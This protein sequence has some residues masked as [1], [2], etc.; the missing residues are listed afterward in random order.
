M[1]RLLFLTLMT[2][3]NLILQSISKEFLPLLNRR[4][5]QQNLPLIVNI[6]IV[7]IN[8]FILLAWLTFALSQF[9]IL[10]KIRN[11]GG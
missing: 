5:Q 7:L 10:N 1:R 3:L 2:L 9:H 4:I 6:D 8:I 11:K